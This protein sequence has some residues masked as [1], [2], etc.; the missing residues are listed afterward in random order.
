MVTSALR[1]VAGFVGNFVAF[2]GPTVESVK[3]LRVLR[4]TADVMENVSP[5]KHVIIEG[6]ASWADS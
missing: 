2:V 6:G 1:G 5:R 3:G 4:S